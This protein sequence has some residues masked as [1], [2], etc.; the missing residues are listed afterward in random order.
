MLCF[1]YYKSILNHPF[2]LNYVSY[3]TTLKEHGK[4]VELSN[5]IFYFF[6]E[7]KKNHRILFTRL[8]GFFLFLSIILWFALSL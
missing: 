7:I 6:G 8:D 2:C 3:R 4:D 1:G 5:N